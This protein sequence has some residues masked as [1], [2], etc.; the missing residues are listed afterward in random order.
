MFYV[1]LDKNI[2]LKLDYLWSYN[3]D[4]HID[5]SSIYAYTYII[6]RWANDCSI[7][8]KTKFRINRSLQKFI[9]IRLYYWY[10]GFLILYYFHTKN[11]T[12]LWTYW[13]CCNFSSTCGKMAGII[14]ALM[15]WLQAVSPTHTSRMLVLRRSFWRVLMRRRMSSCSGC[16]NRHTAK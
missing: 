5:P 7:S 14:S 11:F 6:H 13:G 2:W 16:R 10:V 9:F 4:F 12:N 15:S 8:C 1:I 3:A